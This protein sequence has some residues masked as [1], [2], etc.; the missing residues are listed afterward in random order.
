PAPVR[1]P[2][3]RLRLR[4]APPS[5]TVEPVAIAPAPV[6]T[7]LP[8][9]GD[10]QLAGALRA[11]TGAGGG[12]GGTGAGAGG[13]GSGPGGACDMVRRLQEALRADP[14]IRA[15]VAGA[16]VAPGSGGRAVLVWNGDWVQSPGQAGRGLAGVRQAIAL[17]IAFAPRECRDQTVRG[18]AVIA[19]A[20]G[21][22][23][24]RLALGTGSWRW[25]DLL[26]AG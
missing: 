2:P 22:G 15:A 1:P 9:L 16:R 24:P 19:L 11:G 3:P 7:P 18:Y 6:E 5:P 17:E 20:D 12:A 14:D 4:P 8:T 21:P 23:A 25:R 13:G 10:A 26:G